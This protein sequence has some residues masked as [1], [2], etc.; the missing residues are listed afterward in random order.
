MSFKAHYVGKAII[1]DDPVEFDQGQ[2]FI[3]SPVTSPS[4]HKPTTRRGFTARELLENGFVGLWKERTDI[5]DSAEFSRRLREQS[6]A[7]RYKL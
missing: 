2:E 5:T 6:N 4:S 3:V 7:P 1:P